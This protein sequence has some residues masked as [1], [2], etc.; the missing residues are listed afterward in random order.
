MRKKPL[1]NLLHV[2][3]ASFAILAVLAVNGCIFGPGDT[4][5]KEPPPGL[6]TPAGVVEAIEV[7]YNARDIE[8]YKE[9]LSPN[10]TFYFDP[11]DVGH[12]VGE[13][14]TIPDSW[15]YDEEI[16]AVEN[17]FDQLH[18]IDLSLTSSNIG[19]PG[20]NDTK[21]TA[22]NVQIRLLVMV[23]PVNGFLAQGFVEFDF[24]SYMSPKGK[25]LWRVKNWRDFTSPD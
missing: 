1:I 9:C 18:S 5:R 20:L 17:M 15:G 8:D 13:D 22:S 6:D 2:G 3:I 23:D 4:E 21:F 11:N 7:A 25:K 19:D 10:F 16:P 24:E 14:Y 12:D